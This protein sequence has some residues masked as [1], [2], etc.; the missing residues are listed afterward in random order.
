MQNRIEIDG[1]GE[2]QPTTF[3]WSF[4]TTSTQDSGRA[5]SGAAYISPMFTVESYSV[6]YNNLTIAQCSTILQKIVQKP[7]KPYFTLKY[8]SPYH[9][10]WRTGQFYVGQGT[11]QVRTLKEGTESVQQ[12]SCNFI[13]RE[14]IT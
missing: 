12:I 2:V 10:E 3:D 14:K 13:G 9:G 7:G 5:L 11:L 1:Y 8:F 6:V 4:E